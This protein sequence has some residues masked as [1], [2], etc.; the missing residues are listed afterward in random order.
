MDED[1]LVPGKLAYIPEP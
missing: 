1:T